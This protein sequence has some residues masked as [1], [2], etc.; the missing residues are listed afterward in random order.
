[1]TDWCDLA[2][3]FYIPRIHKFHNE[4]S[5]FEHFSDFIKY[6]FNRCIS[7]RADVRI[8]ARPDGSLFKMA[9]IILDDPCP[10][11]SNSSESRIH[12]SNNEYWMVLDY[13][14]SFPMNQKCAQTQLERHIKCKDDIIYDLEGEVFHEGLWRDVAQKY[15]LEAAEYDRMIIDLEY[16]STKQNNVIITQEREILDLKKHVKELKKNQDTEPDYCIIDEY[17]GCDVDGEGGLDP[18][19]SIE[20]NKKGFPTVG[21]LRLN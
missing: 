17:T 3:R 14:G 6:R 1:M 2:T 15:E 11:L 9:F 8:R 21:G 5:V 16:Q 13:T 18:D 4:A 19:P 10:E 7:G 12:I 20:L